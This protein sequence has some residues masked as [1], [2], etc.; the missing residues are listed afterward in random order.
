[1]EKLEEQAEMLEKVLE[2]AGDSHDLLKIVCDRLQ[3]ML[4]VVGSDAADHDLRQSL[5]LID[6]E[7][8]RLAPISG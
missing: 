1:M 6:R 7:R 8:R 2:H 5:E 3:A 4:D